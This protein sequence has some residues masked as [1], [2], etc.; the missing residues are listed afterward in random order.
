MT[1][2]CWGLGIGVSTAC[3]YGLTIF[4]FSN[5]PGDFGRLTRFLG[6]FMH[7]LN[8]LPDIGTF[9]LLVAGVEN[10]SIATIAWTVFG[11]R[12]AF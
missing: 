10:F 3:R 6:P 9:A 7:D 4:N 12:L 8:D 1:G 5:V 2:K 11:I